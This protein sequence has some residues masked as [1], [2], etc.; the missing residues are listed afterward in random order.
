M[1]EDGQQLHQ[2]GVDS[3]KMWWLKG[4]LGEAGVL[5]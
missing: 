1:K 4:Y 5:A 3:F 2:V